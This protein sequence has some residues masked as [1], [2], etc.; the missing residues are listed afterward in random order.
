V[1]WID[2][3]AAVFEIDLTEYRVSPGTLVFLSPYRRVHITPSR[4]VR[5]MA[6]RFHANF[7]CVETFHAE[8]GCSG[9]LFNDPFGSPA[10]PLA[11]EDRPEARALI[12]R[13]S[14][15]LETRREGHQEIVTAS[16][17]IL[18]VLATRVKNASGQARVRI[19]SDHRHPLLQQ[20]GE[21]VERHYRERHSPAEYATL[22]HM[23]PKALARFARAQLGKTMTEVVRERILID[24]KW[25]LLHTLK[26]V[27]QIAAELGFED[28]LY[29]SRFFKKAT[30]QAPTAF[31]EFE[32][33][34][35]GGSNLSMSLARPAI[36]L[37][38]AGDRP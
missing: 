37:P 3:G 29:F 18:L 35:R 7:L 30:G 22:L 8:S 38:Q 17:K 11:R 10:V 33:R 31:R 32:T 21:L 13:I 36:P 24:A 6:V 15:E 2:S 5:G 4:P 34:I 9:V 16:L 26:P 20:L 25:D 27:K 12:E 28:E 14:L 19:N 23:T 1:Y